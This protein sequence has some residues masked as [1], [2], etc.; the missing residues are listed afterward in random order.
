MSG[1]VARVDFLG[2]GNA[3]CPSGRMHALAILDEKILIDAPPTLL[4][5]L[6]RS[7]ISTGQIEHILFTHWHGDHA[8]GFPFL[9]LDR[10]YIILG[11]ILRRMPDEGK[12]TYCTFW[13][14]A[15]KEI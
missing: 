12:Q 10:K 3:F 5:Q 4:V 8:F 2:T 1:Y 13:P 9:I 7:N 11:C 15:R 6:R 14:R